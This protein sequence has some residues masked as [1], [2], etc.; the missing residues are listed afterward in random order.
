MG[1]P[2]EHLRRCSGSDAAGKL[3]GR[4]GAVSLERYVPVDGANDDLRPNA[5]KLITVER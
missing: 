1:V 5:T 2:G 3:G 4:E